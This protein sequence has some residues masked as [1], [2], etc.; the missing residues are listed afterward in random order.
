LPRWH[1][2]ITGFLDAPRGKAVDRKGD[3]APA[4]QQI[5][6]ATAGIFREPAAAVEIDD[7]GKRSASVRL[8]EITFNGR[9]QLCQGFAALNSLTLLELPHDIRRAFELDQ[10]LRLRANSLAAESNCES[11]HAGRCWGGALLQLDPE[12]I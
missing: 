7:S 9:R 12:A 8:R 4:R 6:D 1:P 10:L 2:S 5:G 11:H 3:I